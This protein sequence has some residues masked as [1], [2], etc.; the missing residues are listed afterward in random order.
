M[1]SSDPATLPDYETVAAALQRSGMPQCPA[2]LHGFALGMAV[3]GV[4]RPLFVWQQ[5]VYAEFD[6]DDVLDSEARALLDRVFATAL[7][8]GRDAAAGLGLL[9]PSDIVVDARR[10]GALRYWCQGFIFGIGC[11]GDGIESRFTD[12]SRELINDIAEITRLDVED[13]DNSDEGRAALIEVE[14]YVREGVM[15]IR[16]EL[17]T[18]IGPDTAST[19]QGR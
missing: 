16:A 19:G 18:A 6:P 4:E 13:A 1:G 2:E 15:L 11:A 17:A 9:L 12:T 5:E 10:L 14:E 7:A 3:A 8:S